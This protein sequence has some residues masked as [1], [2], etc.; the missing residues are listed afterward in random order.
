[1]ISKKK[2]FKNVTDNASRMI[3]TYKF[4]LFID[5][6]VEQGGDQ[7]NL[8]SHSAPIFDDYDRK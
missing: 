3:K 5:E 2:I 8:T 6:E 7:S 4:G 1:M